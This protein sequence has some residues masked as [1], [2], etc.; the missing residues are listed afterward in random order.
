MFVISTKKIKFCKIDDLCPGIGVR[1]RG[2]F[3]AFFETIS[4]FSAKAGHPAR[5]IME[6][7][8]DII[9]EPIG[10]VAAPIIADATA[11]SFVDK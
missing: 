9:V 4:N 6:N 8:A 11:T 10:G 7:I 5:T 2:F 3:P 1:S